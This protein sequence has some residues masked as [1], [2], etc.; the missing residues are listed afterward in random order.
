MTL[1]LI[2]G[3]R[4]DFNGDGVDDTVDVD[5]YDFRS[6]TQSKRS[7]ERPCER[8]HNV[9]PQFQ[10]SLKGAARGVLSTADCPACPRSW[11]PAR[12]EGAN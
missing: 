11:L 12:V 6:G 7:R 10:D 2:D 8:A 9:S 3:M 5:G 4:D 1:R